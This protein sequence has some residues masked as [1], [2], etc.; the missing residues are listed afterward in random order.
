MELGI[1]AWSLHRSISESRE[2]T[3]LQF[4]GIC[5]DEFGVKVIELC[6]QFFPGTDTGYLNELRQAIEGAG[7][8]VLNI[9]I[10]M[11][12]I[13][14][15]DDKERR[16][17]IEGLKQWFH[18]AK[19][20]GSEAVRI[21]TGRADPVTQEVLDRIVAG[22]RELVGE[23]ERAG[24]RVLLE[25]HGGPS[26]DPNS[27]RYFIE[28]VES[29]WFCTC[30]DFGNF[31]PGKLEEALE[32]MMPYAHSVHAK[33]FDQGRMQRDPRSQLPPDFPGFDLQRCLEIVK[34]SGY[35]G[36]LCLEFD[37]PGDE[38]EGIRK[39]LALLQEM[40]QRVGLCLG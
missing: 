14:A 37:G 7:V 23:G 39:S 24:V 1:G 35:D 5:A 19:A 36:P 28:S 27:I 22:Y 17:D 31:P 4:P 16:T 12:N 13:A 38:R 15:A 29:E 8:R 25:N 40:M 9:S 20:V 11:G 3:L 34:A 10:A 32:L 2:I 21:K 6:S 18:V 26:D 30:P 33:L